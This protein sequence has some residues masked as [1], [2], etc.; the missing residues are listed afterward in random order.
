MGFALLP[1]ARSA[2]AWSPPRPTAKPIRRAPVVP[3]ADVVVPGV[4]TGAGWSFLDGAQAEAGPVPAGYLVEVRVDRIGFRVG[5]RPVPPRPLARMIAARKPGTGRP[6]VMVTTGTVAGRAADMLFGALADALG[7][8][9]IAADGP[10]RRNA[11]GVLATGG[12]FRRWCPR[13]TPAGERMPARRT[14]VLGNTLPARPAPSPPRLRPPR[15]APDRPA[16]P[17]SVPETAPGAKAIRPPITEP[18]GEAPVPPITEAV[19]QAPASPA[20]EAV[21]EAPTALDPGLAALLAP[22]RLRGKAMATRIEVPARSPTPPAGPSPAAPPAWPPVPATVPATVPASSIPDAIHAGRPTVAA[23]PDPRS[24][25]PEAGPAK[26]EERPAGPGGTSRAVPRWISAKEIE[27][28]IGDRAALRQAL[29]GRYDAHARVVTR[30]LAEEPGLRARAGAGT[31]SLADLTSGLV[32]VRAYVEDRD[33]IN[34]ILRGTGPDDEADRVAALARF[35]AHGLQRL[36]A[37]LGPVFRAGT[38]T[39][40]A[41]A[42]YRPGATL[43]EPAFVDVDLAPT[44]APGTQVVIWSASAR[45]LKSLGSGERGGGA[46]F[47][48]GSRF[49]VLAVDRD[50]AGQAP[51]RVLLRDLA[52]TRPGRRAGGAP[53]GPDE[54]ERIVARLRATTTGGE[55]RPDDASPAFAPG[56]DE[57]GRPFPPPLGKDG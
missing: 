46:L 30:V 48:P 47:P 44:P 29:A 52:A 1:P 41:V 5:G 16:Q 15:V 53:A 55:A 14:S 13:R 22:D 38:I 17:G 37:V 50:D 9:V 2:T 20:A 45:R 54:S 8:P 42:G 40:E 26:S 36:P 4:R 24:D 23:P 6:V 19:D 51:T 27:E 49:Q 39:P 31:G 18:A 12:V 33:L 28:K 32:A 56:L 35:A 3:Q 10:V 57:E 25:E 34:R 43:I 21:D 7:T 11:L